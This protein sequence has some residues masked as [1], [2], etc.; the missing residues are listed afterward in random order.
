MTPALD[1]SQFKAVASN[2]R[3]LLV[4]AGPGSGKTRVLS[5]RFVRLVKE[6]ADP[7]RILAVTFTNRA[8]REMKERISTEL[9]GRAPL[10]IS[11][12]H[13]LAL[14][15]LRRQRPD[16]RLITRV[17]ARALL[18]EL[19]ALEPD[20]ALDR[21][22]AFKN[23]MRGE[24]GM[25]R[26]LFDSYSQ[27][28]KDSRALD[29]DDLVPEAARLI[30]RQGNPPFDHVMIDEYQD[31]NP[32]QAA[33]VKALSRGAKSLMAIGDPDQAIY[34]F[35]GSSIRCFLD[36]ERE[37][38]DA[39][40]VCL[41]RNYRSGRTI[42]EASRALISN[43]KE[44]LDNDIRPEMEGGS[45]TGIEFGDER[46]EAAFIIREVE[47]LM[48]G[49]TSLTASYDTGHRFSDFAVLCRTNRLSEHIAG[50]FGRSAIPFHLVKPPGPALAG[51]LRSM[52]GRELPEGVEAVH[53]L[54]EEGLKAGIEGEWLEGISPGAGEETSLDAIVDELMLS[55]P[56]DNI[57]IKADK[58]NIMTLHSAKGL[59]WRC[60]FLAGVED[61]LVPM[62]LKGDCDIEEERRLFYVGMTRAKERLFISRAR[63]RR[64]WGEQRE[65]KWSPFIDEIPAALM[66]R[67]SVEKKMPQRRP[68]QKGLFE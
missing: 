32:M 58:V 38:E 1:S 60:V 65:G 39:E 40:R 68:V 59:E 23:G 9:G 12:F 57:D 36:F 66:D 26:P 5:A 7:G 42:V 29:F 45:I 52:R 44:R 24:G 47:R 30:E 46:E 63:T 14:R 35:R 21:I 19:G 61:G 8:A 51:F 50:E 6:G 33:F 37:Y 15:I 4:V 20:K 55:I 34:S 18:K 56:S 64:V 2:A 41:S 49:L 16:L 28:L 31:I 11:T 13:S 10:N 43:N 22:S 3:C 48:G 54:K 53:F 62:R 27:R 67:R 17:E 25:D